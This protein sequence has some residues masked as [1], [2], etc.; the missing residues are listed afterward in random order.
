MS[1]L[2]SAAELP[3][4]GPAIPV[5][6]VGADGLDA[7]LSE[8]SGMQRRFVEASGFAARE[9]EIALVPDTEG[10]LARVLFGLGKNKA[11]K[12]FLTGRLAQSLPAGTYRLA[13]EVKD[14]RLAALGFA[15]GGY[16][17]ARYRGGKE[18][19][20]EKT[21]PRLA[22]PPELD[23]SELENTADSV[24]LARDLINIPANDLGPAEL[25][26]ACRD[27]AEAC[28]ADISVV[29]G[30]ELE[31][32]F[33]LI[34]TVGAGSD[35][36][37]RLVDIRWGEADAPKVTLVGKGVV[38]DTGGLDIKPPS[39]MLLM[40]KDMGGAANVLGL[41]RMVMRAGLKLRLRVLVP[42]VENAIS[43][44]AFR[45]GDV[46]KSRKGLNVEI[47]NTDAE[48][49]LV[50][51][52]ALALAEEETPELIVSMATLTGAARVALGPDLPAFF[53][54]DDG[55]ASALEAAARA[56]HDPFWRLPLWP[57]YDSWLASDIADVNHIASNAYAG[58]IVAALFLKRF[59]EK[60]AYAHFDIFA[61]APK[62]RPLGP[63]G[64]EAQAIR[65][66]FTYL[67]ERY[68]R[69]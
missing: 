15:L 55:L 19:G 57:D 52:D 68:G 62:A 53:A 40:K 35:R 60:S 45:P 4:D 33:P 5:F 18:G 42:A 29:E 7:A 32:E 39:S 37:P 44:R 23:A 26:A 13:G 11:H 49:R 59:V 24:A 66:L 12:P 63:K 17:F 51:A 1:L 67:A 48:G 22:V 54:T 65:A 21:R 16:R 10:A 3:G 43:G 36:P 50:L 25:T 31:K 27:L 30:A 8:L 61:W 14:A 20:E 2:I 56:E 46:L 69:G 9:A 58:A 41:A 34:A 64:G 6:L 47:G 38:F 28:G